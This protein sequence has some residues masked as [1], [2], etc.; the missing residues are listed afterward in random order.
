MQ[1]PFE[2]TF[3]VMDLCVISCPSVSH[4]MPYAMVTLQRGASWLVAGLAGSDSPA[5]QTLSTS[6]LNNLHGCSLSWL[7]LGLIPGD[8]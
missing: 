2:P 1:N 8:F 5:L 7:L 6:G 3:S 4:A